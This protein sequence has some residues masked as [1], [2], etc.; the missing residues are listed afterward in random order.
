[1]NKDFLKPEE[2][3][4]EIE[5]K[6]NMIAADFGCGSGGWVIPLSKKLDKGRI[7][8]I[9]ILEEPL[10]V[11]ESTCKANNII[12]VKTMLSDI[13]KE[14]GSTLKDESVHLVLLTNLLFQVEDKELVI[15][16]AERILKKGGMVLIA[17]WKQNA[18]FG[19]QEGKISIENVKEMAEKLGLKFRKEIEAGTYH[20]ALLFNK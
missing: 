12:G 6:E 19:P 18:Y 15:K 14:K 7:F 4:N 5:L 9:D 2:I 13:E 20:Y 8:A 16:E 11:L 17:D 3:L 1:M 10:S